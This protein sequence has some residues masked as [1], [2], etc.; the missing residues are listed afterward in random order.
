MTLFAPFSF[1]LIGPLGVSGF[2]VIHSSFS[3]DS[4]PKSRSSDFL[5]FVDFVFLLDFEDLLDFELFTDFESE[6]FADFGV[7]GV[8]GVLGFFTFL[9]CLEWVGTRGRF[10]APSSSS[11]ELD[12]DLNS[13]PIFGFFFFVVLSLS[14]S[15]SLALELVGR[16]NRPPKRLW[17]VPA[18]LNVTGAS[19]SASLTYP[20]ANLPL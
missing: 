19:S 6:N 2:L 12:N 9:S 7:L 13:A 18:L 8:L 17:F 14:L 5:D 4:V 11:D 15:L 1:V 3:S 10:H 20:P 16:R